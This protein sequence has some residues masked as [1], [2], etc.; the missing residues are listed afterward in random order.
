MSWEDGSVSLMPLQ[1]SFLFPLH[2]GEM[3]EG[4]LDADMT[5]S[6]HAPPPSSNSSNSSGSGR[7][8]GGNVCPAAGATIEGE[9]ESE[10]A[11]DQDEEDELQGKRSS[12]HPSSTVQEEGKAT[13]WGLTDHLHVILQFDV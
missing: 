9:D 3:V 6:R 1:L 13:F 5:A 12:V 11:Q 2:V 4:Q 7:C 8:G 10:Q